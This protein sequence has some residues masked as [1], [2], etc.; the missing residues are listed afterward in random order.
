VGISCCDG[1]LVGLINGGVLATL[2]SLVEGEDAR[3]LLLLGE[4]YAMTTLTS[5][6][7]VDLLL[8]SSVFL[9]GGV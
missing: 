5:F 7:G 3:E 2:G 9:L 4:R 6:D 8:C 1:G